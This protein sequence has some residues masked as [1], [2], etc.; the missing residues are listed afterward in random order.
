VHETKYGK[1]LL[2]ADD[3]LTPSTVPYRRRPYVTQ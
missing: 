1:F 3:L 2:D